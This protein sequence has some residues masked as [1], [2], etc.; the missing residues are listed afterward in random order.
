[1][2]ELVPDDALELLAIHR[3]SSPV[4]TATDACAGSRPVAKAFWLPS[5]TTKTPGS[6]M[7]AAIDS[8]DDIEQ[9]RVARRDR[10]PGTGGLEDD[11]G[12]EPMCPG[13]R[14]QPDEGRD[15]AGP[16]AGTG[17]KVRVTAMISAVA[18]TIPI[19]VMMS[20]TLFRRL[21]DA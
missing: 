17:S 20:S 9:H 11:V 18:A 7:F 19:S 8:P 12:P 1:M 4:V 15:S 2:A 6:G 10:Q 5:S 21:A 14:T 16:R 3:S 13:R